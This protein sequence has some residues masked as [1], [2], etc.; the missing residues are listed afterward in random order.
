MFVT[1]SVLLSIHY[2]WPMETFAAPAFF[3]R[4]DQERS[5]LIYEVL[6]HAD[7]VARATLWNWRGG[8][9]DSMVVELAWLV[10]TGVDTAESRER[11]DVWNENTTMIRGSRAV[12]DN[13][14]GVDDG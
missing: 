4:S 12:E 13:V 9:N 14:G 1:V 3:L 8:S 10:G 6:Q 5:G 11:D 7:A 2:T